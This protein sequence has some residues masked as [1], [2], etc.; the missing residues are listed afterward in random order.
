MMRVRFTAIDNPSNSILEAG[1]DGFMFRSYTCGG[2]VEGDVDGDGD[3]DVEDLLA[4]LSNWGPCSGCPADLDGD[5]Q[6]G[7]SDLLTVLANWS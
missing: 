5:G 6:V 3:V 2:G 1:V 4:V 7:V